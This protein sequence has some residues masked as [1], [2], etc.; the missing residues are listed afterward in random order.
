MNRAE[1]AKF[2]GPFEPDP[3]HTG[4][5]RDGWNGIPPPTSEELGGVGYE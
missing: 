5:G 3:V 4:G 1:I 2:A